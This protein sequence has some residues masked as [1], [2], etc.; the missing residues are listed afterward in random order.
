MKKSLLILSLV[1]VIYLLLAPMAETKV[2]PPTLSSTS[3]SGFNSLG[4]NISVRVGQVFNGETNYVVASNPPDS[5]GECNP[6]KLATGV[7]QVFRPN[8]ETLL[9]DLPKT[10]SGNVKL[11]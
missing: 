9:I 10:S 7:I 11:I 3:T 4:C 6:K 8:L 2:L 5:N 1:F